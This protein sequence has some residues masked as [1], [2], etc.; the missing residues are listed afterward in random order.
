[1]DL[2]I[3]FNYA[4]KKRIKS[5]GFLPTFINYSYRFYKRNALRMENALLLNQLVL[6][7]YSPQLDQVLA[8]RRG[9][10]RKRCR[11]RRHPL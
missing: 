11:A 4:L 5:L 6:S 8:L 7:H 1:M 3:L 2:L 9:I 10:S